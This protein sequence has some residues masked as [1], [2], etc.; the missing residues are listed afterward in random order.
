MNTQVNP[1]TTRGD[2]QSTAIPNA[3]GVTVS[4]ADG[5]GQMFD[6]IAHRYDLLNRVISLRFDQGWRRKLIAALPSSGELL[7]VATGTADVAISLASLS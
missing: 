4:G 5:S 6:Q 1:E 3:P 7:D 2:A